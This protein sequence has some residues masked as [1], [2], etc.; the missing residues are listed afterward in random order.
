MEQLTG[1]LL[2]TLDLFYP[3]L[4]A[5]ILTLVY[6]IRKRS[7][8][9]MIVS[10]VLLYPDAWFFSGYPSFAWVKFLPVIEVIFAIVFWVKKQ[11]NK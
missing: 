8:F 3:L 10:A 7:W 2:G 6:A 9:W 1:F 5:S 4:I 11:Q